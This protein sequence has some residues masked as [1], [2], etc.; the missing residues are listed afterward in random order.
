MFSALGFGIAEARQRAFLLYAYEV[1]ESVLRQQ[2]SPAQKA[3]RRTLM[4]RLLLAP[5]P[6]EGLAPR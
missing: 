4:E 6:A 5:L 1:A 3:E 2:G